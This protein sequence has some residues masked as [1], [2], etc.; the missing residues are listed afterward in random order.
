M[1]PLPSFL[2]IAKITALAT[3]V[4]ALVQYV[5]DK[6]PSWAIKPYLQIAFGVGLSLWWDSY[7]LPAGTPF[8]MVNWVVVLTNGVLAGIFAD[9]GF[10]FL[11]AQP[12][13]PTF[14][15][16]KKTDGT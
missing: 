10:N 13:S 5:K 2:D 1:P 14:S 11:S 16:P 4:L 6:V 15:L 7:V 9:L 8:Y 3:L 12:G